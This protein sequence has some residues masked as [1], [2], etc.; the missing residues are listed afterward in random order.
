MCSMLKSSR[1]AVFVE[2]ARETQFKAIHAARDEEA[3]EGKAKNM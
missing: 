3:S 2:L 1:K